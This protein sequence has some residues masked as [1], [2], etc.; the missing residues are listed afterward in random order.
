[1]NVAFWTL[2]NGKAFVH[3][4]LGTTAGHREWEMQE[5][6]RWYERLASKRKLVRY[7]NRGEGL[8][9]GDVSV[10]SL[11]A[12]VVDL[13]A[14]VDQLGLEQ[15]ILFGPW[16]GGPPA[17]AYAARHPERLSHLILWCTFGRGSEWLRQSQLQ[18]ARSLID[19]N[20][21][22]YTETVAHVIFGWPEGEPAGRYAA[23]LRESIT[24]ERLENWYAE[25]SEWDVSGLL[26]QI[27]VPTLVLHRRRHSLGL[28]VP[29]GLAA[30]IPNSEL[31]LLDGDST[32]P[33]LGETEAVLQAIDEFLREGEALPETPRTIDAEPCAPGNLTAREVEVLGLIAGGRTNREIAEAL[34]LSVRT[35]AR[36]S[37]NIYAKIGARSRS[38]ATAYAIR[39]GLA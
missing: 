20:W 15:F 8:T 17:I 14:V 2:G 39:H 5:C 30:G 13:E 37:T 9:D 11:E 12:S 1:V 16:Y 4:T 21:T 10:R 22:V 38:E 29:R 34:T 24:P 35:V 6:R 25:V 32:A 26:P 18:A 31:V 33:Y 3:L 19:K 23:L 28:D 7:D 36:H 27:S